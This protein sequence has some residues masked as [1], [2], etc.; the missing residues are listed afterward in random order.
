[1]TRTI[2]YG[3]VAGF[4]AVL[5]FHQG[6]AF[7]LHHV[8]NGLGPSVALFGRVPAPFNMAAVPP[9]GVPQVLS[10]AFW[11][12]VWGILLALLLRWLRVPALLFGLVFGAV[13]AT[14]V[15]FTLVA[16]MKGLPL[17]AG[18]NRQVWARALLYNGAWGWGTALLLLRP[19]GLR[20]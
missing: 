11:G 9:L 20:A 7:L 17:W 2:L 8:G 19:L 10:L 16:Q 13:A 4:L 1:M 3:F 5:V 14:L 6:T 12:G 15:A 18:G